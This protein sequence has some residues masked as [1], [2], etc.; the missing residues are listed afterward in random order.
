MAGA[1]LG[2]AMTFL[3]DPGRGARRRA[4]VRDAA[5]HGLTVTRR[6]LGTAARDSAP[7]TYG[8]AAS[9]RSRLRL[10]A[11]VDDAVLAERVRAKLGRLVSHPH[12][13]DVIA[14][15]GFVTLRGPVLER[16]AP[17]LVQRLRRIRGVRQIIDNL[18]YH[19]QAGN[20]PSL[21]GGRAPAGDRP[22]VLQLHWAPATRMLVGAAAALLMAGGV[23]RR[24]MPGAF[25]AL[26]GL[27][28]AARAAINAPVRR[29][30]GLGSRRRAIDVQ[31]TITIN[32]PLG[33]VYAFW[34]E[35][36]N[37]PRFMSRVLE[38]RES[39][40]HPRRSHWKVAGPAGL[41]V[42]FDAEITRVVPNRLLAWKT[43]PGAM[44]AHAGVVRMDP[45]TEG[46]TRVQVRLSYNPPAGWL[47]HG[48]AAM[49]GGDPKTSMDEDLVRMK[50]LIETGHAARDAAA[51]RPD[52]GN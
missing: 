47:G 33:E 51:R 6:G 23:L 37:F 22:D 16:E 11:R 21:Q 9:L 5:V 18:E 36:G 10:R 25:A 19:E 31:K 27:G 43:L 24:D 44:V 48:V 17:R 52:E 8:T 15:S 32:A 40:R 46:A 26:L 50:T 30:I 28:V 49:F 3:L 34:S 13:I 4:R 7:R 35:Y 38:V 45:T 42:A 1:G 39:E 29:L 41:P 14:S 2:A 20:V 12:A